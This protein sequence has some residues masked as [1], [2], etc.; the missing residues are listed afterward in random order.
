MQANSQSQNPYRKQVPVISSPGRAAYITYGQA[1]KS[2]VLTKPLYFIF[3]FIYNLTDRTGFKTGKPGYAR[4]IA[5]F[6]ITT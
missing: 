3:L 5:G 1:I 4:C 2:C 6:L